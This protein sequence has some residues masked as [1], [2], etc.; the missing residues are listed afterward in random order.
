M[1]RN[2]RIA[3]VDDVAAVRQSL[4]A[5]LETYDYEVELYASAAAFLAGLGDIRLSCVLFDVRMPGMSGLEAQ[6][7]LNDR[8]PWLP[9]IIITGHGDIDMA[10]KAMK[11]GAFDFIEKPIDDQ[12][13]LSSIAAAVARASAARDED[14]RRAEA[15]RKY[16]RLTNRERDVMRLVAEGYSTLAIASLLAISARTVDHHRASIQAKLEVTSLPQLIKLALM[17]DRGA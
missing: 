16:E 11:E 4:K 13:L 1:S 2:Q 17:L 9:A 14:R 8:A 15:R 6:R 10:V 3:V 12:R 7:L 5:L